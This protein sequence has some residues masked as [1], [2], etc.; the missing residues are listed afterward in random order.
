MKLTYR[1]C[2]ACGQEGSEREVRVVVVEVPLEERIP[3]T[4]AIPA[5][6]REGAVEEQRQVMGQYAAELRCVDVGAC[7][8][9]V[10]A[11]T[12]EQPGE[13]PVAEPEPVTA[14]DEGLGAWMP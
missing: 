7:R 4:V 8:L 10:A 6:F 2:F 9:R 13:A 12:P 3:V 14:L 5:S 1:A 11:L